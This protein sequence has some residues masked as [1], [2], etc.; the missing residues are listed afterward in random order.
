MEISFS[1]TLR[2]FTREERTSVIGGW[3]GRRVGLD[4]VVERYV[5]ASAENRTFI[6]Q[7]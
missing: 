2:S 3:V 5:S 6:P 7:S 1:F 4:A